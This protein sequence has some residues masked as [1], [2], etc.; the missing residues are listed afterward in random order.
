M[1]KVIVLARK[2][3]DIPFE[4]F[5][6]YYTNTHVHLMNGLLEHGAAVHRRNFV[7]HPDP[8]KPG[9]FD[10]I[11]EVFYE[12]R[13]VAEA[14]MREMADPEIHRQRIEDEQR[15]LDPASVQVFMVEEETTVFRPLPQ[16]DWHMQVTDAVLSRRSIRKFLPDPVAPA[17][18]AQVLETA[19]RAPSGGNVQPWNV[20]VVSGGALDRMCA[21]IARLVPQGRAAHNGEYD[22]YPA[23][24]AGRY[25]ASRVEVAES[26]Y[27]AMSIPRED[28]PGRLAHVARNFEAFGAPVLLLVHTPRYMGPPQWADIGM[29]MQTVM[30]LLR[31]AGLDSCPQEAWSLY[32][33]EIRQHVPLPDDHIFFCGISVG[34]RDPDAPVNTFDVT[35]VPLAEVATF[36]S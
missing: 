25:G 16:L 23:Q 6:A 5:R 1:F 27:Q 14:T 31:E 3:A 15:F 29:W 10:V 36:V 35:R 7:I 13:A 11:S 20:H 34:Y 18:L 22:I 4:Q 2:R 28:K 21:A 32:Q 12:D 26:M 30:L 19:Q 33:S 17:I 9:Q 8:E 24:L